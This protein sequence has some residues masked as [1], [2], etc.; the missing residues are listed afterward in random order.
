MKTQLL[1]KS[2]KLRQKAQLARWAKIRKLKILPFETNLRFHIYTPLAKAIIT[3]HE[4]IPFD[5]AK[6]LMWM[7]KKVEESV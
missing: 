2:Q 7:P 3:H 5:L 1:M 4:S 6:K